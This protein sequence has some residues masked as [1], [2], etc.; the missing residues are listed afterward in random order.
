MKRL[1][2]T[3]LLLVFSS[4]T[5]MAAERALLTVS[6][7]M[8][9]NSPPATVWNIIKAFDGIATW[10]PLV[11]KCSLAEGSNGKVGAVRAAQLKGGMLVHEELVAYREQDMT[12][13]Y[14]LLPSP[15]PLDNYVATTSV[16][17]NH[18]NSGSIITWYSNFRRKNFSA[19]PPEG[20]GD[21]AL[22][23]ALSGIYQESMA[24]VK[25][26]AEKN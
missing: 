20:E 4:I 2:I 21:A 18:D 11:E 22:I 14:A 19:N 6:E 10:I 25:K 8:E 26:M 9:V 1:V 12:F 13:S 15:F 23:K 3:G 5:S 17:P 7:V 16:K 24:V